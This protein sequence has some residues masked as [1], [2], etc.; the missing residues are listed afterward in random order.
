MN[1]VDKNH[2]RGPQPV[3]HEALGNL[4]KYYGWDQAIL[5]ARTEDGDECVTTSGIGY[6]NGKIAQEMGEFMKFKVMGWQHDTSLDEE[7]AKAK[8]EMA[9]GPENDPLA[10]KR[11]IMDSIANTRR[12]SITKRGPKGTAKKAWD[13]LGGPGGKAGNKRPT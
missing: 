11:I 7:I 12:D 13:R 4:M 1:I 2:A 6:R 9:E 3:S 8:R 5:I 10:G